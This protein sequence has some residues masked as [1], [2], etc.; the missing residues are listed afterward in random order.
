MITMRIIWVPI[1]CKKVIPM[2]T[3]RV[4]KVTTEGPP[5]NPP[6]KNFIEFFI[7]ILI[8]K[9]LLHQVEETFGCTFY[10][11]QHRQRHG[12]GGCVDETPYKHSV[13][14]RVRT[15][16]HLDWLDVS[17]LGSGPFGLVS[18]HQNGRGGPP[19]P[20]HTHSYWL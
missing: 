11:R 15:R 17:L 10:L 9:L 2:F 12:D 20:A 16:V 4:V 18:F 13:C 14:V 8:F 1:L 19:V 6:T 7:K 5:E 3:V